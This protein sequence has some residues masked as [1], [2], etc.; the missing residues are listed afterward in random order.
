[1]NHTTECFFCGGGTG[2]AYPCICSMPKIAA[3]KKKA[4]CSK[5]EPATQLKPCPHCGKQPRLTHHSNRFDGKKLVSL[6]CCASIFGTPEEVE[7]KWNAR[8]P[9]EQQHDELLAELELAKTDAHNKSLRIQEL[10]SRNA[11]L[12]AALRS[13]VDTYKFMPDEDAIVIMVDTAEKAIIKAG[14][15]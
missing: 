15:V 6:R 10:H 7:A 1:M 5:T 4:T 13:M 8:L 9:A 3:L 11:E 12:L 2:Q 14:A